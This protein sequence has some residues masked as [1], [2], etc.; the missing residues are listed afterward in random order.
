MTLLSKLQYNLI[1]LGS[2]A[3]AGCATN[4]EKDLS[5][6]NIIAIE[7]VDSKK[8]SIGVVNITNAENVFKIQGEIR[9]RA[10]LRGAIPGH[11]DIE[12]IGGDGKIITKLFTNYSR[13]SYKAKF[14]LTLTDPP[15]EDYFVRV[16]HHY[17]TG[18]TYFCC[19]SADVE[20]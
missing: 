17:P 20:K 3:I 6:A 16:T 15:K 14:N 8:A 19:H 11:M 1:I 5:S 7:R 10:K 13:G 4:Q 2:L 18:N 12:L 9:R